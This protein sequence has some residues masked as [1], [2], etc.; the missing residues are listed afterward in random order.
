MST[1]REKRREKKGQRRKDKAKERAK[2]R[3]AK[4]QRQDEEPLEEEMSVES[5]SAA[6]EAEQHEEIDT[7]VHDVQE[8]TNKT[9]RAVMNKQEKTVTV[10]VDT[11]I[12]QE[13]AQI[14]F[15]LPKALKRQIG[16]LAKTVDKKQQELMTEAVCDILHK[17]GEVPVA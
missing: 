16:I 13:V 5:E 14:S 9:Q 8:S 7:V 4:K 12:E 17:Y 6:S 2:E 15:R 3:K 1:S 11:E 10:P